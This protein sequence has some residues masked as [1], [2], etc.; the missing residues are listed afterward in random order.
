V[1]VEHFS[2]QK[3]QLNSDQSWVMLKFRKKVR[4]RQGREGRRMAW[5]FPPKGRFSVNCFL[6]FW[7]LFLSTWCQ[8]R[9]PVLHHPPP[10]PA[11]SRAVLVHAL[12]L[13]IQSHLQ[14]QPGNTNSLH[15]SLIPFK[16]QSKRWLKR[17]DGKCLWWVLESYLQNLLF[18]WKKKSN[19]ISSQSPF[20][21]ISWKF[22]AG[23]Q[24]LHSFLIKCYSEQHHTRV[25][26]A[27]GFSEMH[28]CTVT[29]S[30]Y[31]VSQQLFICT[32]QKNRCYLSLP[33]TSW[34]KVKRIGCRLSATTIS[35]SHVV[36]SLCLCSG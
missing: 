8:P 35:G 4:V 30:Q 23:F 21:P 28:C 24:S 13:C 22:N 2:C 34:C 19:R 36:L 26:L 14:P 11:H 33:R 17:A 1:R 6:C 16:L 5:S 10:S 27:T 15:A 20:P 18:K 7:Q 3:H 12:Y 31:V 29:P 25:H 9:T 32:D